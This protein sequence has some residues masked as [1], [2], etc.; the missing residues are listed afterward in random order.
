MFVCVCVIL[1]VKFQVCTP[2][3]NWSLSSPPSKMLLPRMDSPDHSTTTFLTVSTVYFLAA[4]SPLSVCSSV[5]I[6]VH[7]CGI[8]GTLVLFS[9]STKVKVYDT[10]HFFPLIVSSVLF[11]DCIRLYS[12]ASLL[13]S[14]VFTIEMVL[15]H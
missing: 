14:G 8:C 11:C 5:I 9:L 6:L 12:S 3:K 13:C 10:C 7:L 15:C 1:Q 4:Q 2:Q